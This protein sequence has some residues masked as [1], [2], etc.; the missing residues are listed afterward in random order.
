[1]RTKSATG[2]NSTGQKQDH[3]KWTISINNSCPLP[4]D[5][6][7]R[8]ELTFYMKLILNNDWLVKVTH[9]HQYSGITGNA[10]MLGPQDGKGMKIIVNCGGAQCFTKLQGPGYVLDHS[11]HIPLEKGT[12]RPSAIEN[13]CCWS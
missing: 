4:R 2:I 10:P 1:M 11:K 12:R 13:H 5:L 7:D 9:S 8:I 6:A 3:E